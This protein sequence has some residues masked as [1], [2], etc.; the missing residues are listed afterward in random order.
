MSFDCRIIRKRMAITLGND[1]IFI[2][3]KI[4]FSGLIVPA[5]LSQN[6]IYTNQED[7]HQ[8]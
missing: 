3:K 8:E 5:V 2:R 7:Q 4:T 1:I 6:K